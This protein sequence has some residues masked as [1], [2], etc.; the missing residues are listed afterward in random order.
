MEPWSMEAGVITEDITRVPRMP[1]DNANN[2]ERTQSL[3]ACKL[4]TSPSGLTFR[5]L[6]ASTAH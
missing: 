4:W 1:D 5:D 6:L 3:R 2:Q